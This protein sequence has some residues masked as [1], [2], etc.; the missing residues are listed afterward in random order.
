MGAGLH[1]AARRAEPQ[2]HGWDIIAHDW[3]G[4]LCATLCRTRE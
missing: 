2:A 4:W 1:A 3:Q